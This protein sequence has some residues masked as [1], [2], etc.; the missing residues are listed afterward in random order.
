MLSVLT[1]VM[2]T[3]VYLFVKRLQFM[4]LPESEVLNPL[5]SSYSFFF[6]L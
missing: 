5:S 2:L 6:I 4:L 1:G 3:G